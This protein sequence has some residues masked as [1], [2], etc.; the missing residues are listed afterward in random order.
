V[1]RHGVSRIYFDY[2]ATTPMRTEVID[3]MQAALLDGGF[4][5]SS[6]HAEGRRARALLDDA[7]DRVAASLGADRKEIT[8]T[9]SGTEADNLAIYGV[10][11]ARGG[12]GRVVA[13][14]VEHHA[15]LHA[16][17]GLRED[18]F[19]VTILPV[20]ESGRV[21][22]ETFAASLGTETLL[23]SVMYANN[24]IGTVQPIAELSALARSRG[25]LFHTDAVQAPSWLPIDVRYLGVDMLSIS[26]HKFYG[27]K[28]VGALYVRD[29]TPLSPIVRG[30]GQEFGRRSGTENVA[31]IVGLAAALELA[32]REREAV[33]AR[34]RH[35]RDRLENGICGAIADV[36]VNG[37]GAPRLPNNLNVSFADVDSEALLVRLDLEGV[38]VSAG[39]AC[40][41]GTLERSHVIAALGTGPRWQT[42]AIRFSLGA[43][44][45]PAEVERVLSILP[46]LVEAM[47]RRAK[48]PA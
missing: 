37:A 47:R 14:A 9:G 36:R 24:E 40:T 8:F 25:V 43:P 13:D 34:V 44:T 1:N 35:L 23:A 33:A 3:A 32:I 26:A 17:D 18:G 5:P 31:G 45:T 46:G 10:A 20:D 28:G 12:R 7:R 22:P 27:P 4:N 2:A 39:S 30:G 6:P 29:G 48:A 19:D 42:G 41:S 38:A 11:R 16:T 15:V 21:D